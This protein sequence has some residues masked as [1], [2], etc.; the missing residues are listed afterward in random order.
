[1]FVGETVK[2]RKNDEL[3]LAKELSEQG[4]S[5]EDIGRRTGCYHFGDGKWRVEIDDS[6]LEL[7]NTF[8]NLLCHGELQHLNVNKI[9]IERTTD[10]TVDLVYF[11]YN[12]NGQT[13]QGI[14]NVQITDLHR[15][16]GVNL[17]VDEL[18]I[19]NNIGQ[20]DLLNVR[21]FFFEG[22]PSTLPIPLCFNESYLRDISPDLYSVMFDINEPIGKNTKAAVT[23]HTN[24]YTTVNVKNEGTPDLVDIQ[25]SLL[26][27]I[28]HIFQRIGD[29]N[30]GSDPSMFKKIDASYNKN[31]ND[32][33]E[34][35]NKVMSKPDL[36]DKLMSHEVFV[37]ELKSI[38]PSTEGFL[39]F[40]A[41][42]ENIQDHYF[43]KNDELYDDFDEHGINLSDYVSAQ[44]PV[45]KADNSE[46]HS[47]LYQYMRTF[48]EIEARVTSNRMHLNAEERRDI[49]PPEL[50][51]GKA[52]N[53]ISLPNQL[54]MYKFNKERRALYGDGD[55]RFT[56]SESYD[57]FSTLHFDSNSTSRDVI[58]GVIK[59]AIEA[60]GALYNELPEGN[61]IRQE[62]ATL[63]GAANLSPKDW[64]K[65]D[66]MTRDNVTELLTNMYIHHCENT[67]QFSGLSN[68]FRSVTESVKRLIHKFPS[69]NKCPIE[70]PQ[71]VT[72]I[73]N[74]MIKDATPKR[75]GF[76]S[77]F[78]DKILNHTSIMPTDALTMGMFTES[79]FEVMSKKSG[80]GFDTLTNRF[81]IQ[82]TGSM[83]RRKPEFFK[84]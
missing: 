18:A 36:W 69:F 23:I 35:K 57:N 61:P 31:I 53:H 62:F 19:P 28:Q 15:Y 43:E 79:V 47:A 50:I 59:T 13:S 66:Y 70:A 21:E 77:D 80:I 68:F 51:T 14:K 3:K 44:Y 1:M 24:G 33:I 12:E 20:S 81:D 65:V 84:L 25:E 52:K 5:Y 40:D 41:M 73:F 71:E 56:V 7:S 83:N 26:H 22:A 63:M 29:L 74:G 67:T 16:L 38:Y 49:L 10:E 48:G 6:E 46:T 45:F 76:Q 58:S 39:D 37:H 17:T 82:V 78:A 30:Q 34:I 54:S 60:Y 75:E 9:G 42:P 27:E 32:Q 4:I 64:S 55:V 2:H 72:R 8:L 11:G